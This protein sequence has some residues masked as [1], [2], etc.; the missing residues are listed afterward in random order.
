MTFKLDLSKAIE[1][2]IKDRDKIIRGTLAQLSTNIIK[3]TPVGNPAL[4][5][6]S[7]LPAPHGYVG[8]SLRGAWNAS[9]GQPDRTK[10]GRIEKAA[11]GQTAGD[12]ASI[13]ASFNAGQ[14]F[15]LTN[16]LPYAGRVEFGHSSQ[17]PNGMLRVNLKQAQSIMDKI[18]K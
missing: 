12:A 3:S 17:R 15:Y 9:F 11:G 7:S 18:A 14:T 4:W 6:P 1:N 13:A 16:P 2:I 5:A 10:T 8:G